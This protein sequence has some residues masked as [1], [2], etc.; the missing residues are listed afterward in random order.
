MFL[1][2]LHMLQATAPGS[3][4]RQ[5]QMNLDLQRHAAAVC[6]EC[7]EFLLSAC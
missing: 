1:D 5:P 6:V 4:C 7:P 2:I 3:V